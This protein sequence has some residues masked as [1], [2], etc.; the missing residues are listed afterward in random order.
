MNKLLIKW[1][2]TGDNNWINYLNTDLYEVIDEDLHGVYVIR[3]EETIVYV[4]SGNIRKRLLDHKKELIIAGK[5]SNLKISW[6]GINE[7]FAKGAERFI[8]DKLKPKEGDQWPD[9][10]PIEVRLPDDS[11]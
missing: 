6:A 2:K 1:E 5:Y 10:E 9:V 3:S 8:A 11:E 4:G 7:I